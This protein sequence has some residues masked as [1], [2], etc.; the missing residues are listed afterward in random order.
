MLLLDNLTSLFFQSRS[1]FP[2]V[3]IARVRINFASAGLVMYR[4][5]R[6]YSEQSI[7]ASAL[8]KNVSGIP[9]RIRHGAHPHKGV[10]CLCRG[11]Y[12]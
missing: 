6:L 4:R 3:R 2:T 7:D 5:R 1:K 8:S 12:E 11:N 9:A 10:A